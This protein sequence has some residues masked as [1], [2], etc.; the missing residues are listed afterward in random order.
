MKKT[1][2]RFYIVLFISAL[3]AGGL[4]SSAHRAF[5][6]SNL[7]NRTLTKL[8]SPTLKSVLDG[9]YEEQMENGLKDQ[10]VLKNASV[11]LSAALDVLT[12]HFD[13][14]GTYFRP[15]GV[16]VKKETNDDYTDERLLINS[17]IISRFAENTKKPLDIC[18]IPPKGSVEPDELPSFAPYLDEKRLREKVAGTLSSEKDVDIVPM[19]EL[20][21]GD[22]EKYFRTDHHY[23]TYGAYLASKDYLTSVGKKISPIEAFRLSTIGED[24]HGTLYRKAPLYD[25]AV[26]RMTIPAEIPDVFINYSYASDGRLKQKGTSTNIYEPKYMFTEDKYSIYFGGNHGLTVVR[27]LENPEGDVLFMIKDSFANSAVP[28]LIRNYSQIVM[29]DLRYFGG[30]VQDAVQKYAP[31]RI[32]VWYESLDFAQEQKFPVLLR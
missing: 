19:H 26:D 30:S 13:K 18:L 31:D 17:R 29:V 22:G 14:N 8:P 4:L 21:S 27:N 24:F 9:S 25:E 20:L 11:K 15:D 28:Y 23:N 10:S 7:E 3:V 5:R 6:F 32:V 16:Y 12:G 1:E 2:I